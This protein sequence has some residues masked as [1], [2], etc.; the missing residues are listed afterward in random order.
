MFFFFQALFRK[1]LTP[2]QS[3]YILVKDA[4]R[5]FLEFVSQKRDIPKYYKGGPFGSAGG[6]ILEGDGASPPPA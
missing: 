6:R 3:Y 4:F 5:K 2:S 1:A